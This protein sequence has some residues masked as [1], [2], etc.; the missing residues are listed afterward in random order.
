MKWYNSV[1]VKLLGFF[2]VISIVFLIT[3]LSVLTMLKNDVLMENAAK[4]VSLTTT[5]IL[6][7]LQNTKSRIE[8]IVLSL[9][10]TSSQLK[11]IPNRA[12]IVKD[13]LRVN[14]SGLVTSGGI[15]F[16]PYAIDEKIR[17]FYY[18][19]NRKPDGK[20]E[21]IENYTQKIDRD[22]GNAEFY[23]VAKY[24]KEG[25]TYWTKVYRD[26]VT[27]VRMITVVSPIYS[28]GAFQGVA[29]VDIK[30]DERSK[31]V[32][33]DFKFPDRY[34]MMLD[35]EGTIMIKSTL[36]SDYLST[37]RVY[38]KDCKSFIQ[39][40]KSI[41]PLFDGCSIPKNYNS[42][43]AKDL[44]SSIDISPQESKRIASILQEKDQ[45][46]NLGI[47]EQIRFVDDDPILKKDSIIATF[48]IQDTRWRV[49]I[50]IPEEQ[51]L[52][53][54]NSMHN[55]IINASILLTILATIVGYFLLN[56]LFIDPIKDIIE[57]LHNNDDDEEGHYR[58]L[59][60]KDKGEIG[61]LVDK[62]NLRTQALQ[63]SRIRE[64]EEIKKRII[65]EKLLVQQSK[66]AA[67]GEMMDSVAHQ[68]KQ[69]LNAVV[70][71]TELLK[72]DFRD[73]MVDDRY[74]DEFQNNIQLQVNHMLS[75]LDEFRTFFRPNKDEEYF[76]ISDIISTVLLLTKDEFMKNSITINIAKDDPVEIYGYKNEFIHLILNIIN[77]AKDAF[78][79]NGIKDRVISF[80]TINSSEEKVLRI[81]DNAGGIPDAIM[82][83]IFEANV[84][85]KPEGKG[86]GIG[87]FMSMQIATK[88]NAT[89]SVENEKDGA[90]FVVEFDT[91]E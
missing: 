18:F 11:S 20:F 3:M 80:Y 89:L 73:D 82:D 72:S 63:R 46:K 65:N 30:I 26:P 44:Q 16:E 37:D 27:N 86:T 50:G 58:L 57:Q 7:N 23:M 81:C 88:H 17:D 62:L 28:K 5:K 55:K 79:E 60:S 2:F 75:T 15:W 68:W 25:Q 64:A 36:L 45:N 84:T 52:H 22:Y 13:I 8:E 54:S 48:H 1:K 77:N 56:S 43:V 33:G 47:T 32:F 6:S 14:D 29:A 85:T 78:V 83:K 90:C 19:F 41:K 4:E 66:M 61:T 10:S 39:K 67:M 71:Y 31:K 9:A 69:P 12:K 42:I 34:L 74:V 49:I 51:V 24:L 87:L 53:E 40:Y 59:K 91:K 21:L 38:T 35:R 76:F 70:M